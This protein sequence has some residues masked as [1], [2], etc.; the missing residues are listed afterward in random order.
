MLFVRTLSVERRRLP[1]LSQRHVGNGQEATSQTSSS[2][3]VAAGENNQLATQPVFEAAVSRGQVVDRHR[4]CV[5]QDTPTDLM[6]LIRLQQETGSIK[7]LEQTVKE[8]L[9]SSCHMFLCAD[10]YNPAPEDSTNINHGISGG[11]STSDDTSPSSTN[12]EPAEEPGPGAMAVV[13]RSS[14]Y[15]RVSK[16][17]GP[18]PPPA[19]TSEEVREEE[20]DSPRLTDRR[21]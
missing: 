15:A 19:P 16:R 17:A 8:S 3:E 10:T 21:S 4:T 18:A 14:L 11:S 2:V 9:V 5:T 1:P 7:A 20:P 6:W 13:D 12:Q